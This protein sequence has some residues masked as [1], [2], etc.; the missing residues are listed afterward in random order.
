MLAGDAESGITSLSDADRAEKTP[1][2]RSTGHPVENQKQLKRSKE[3]K[4]ILNYLTQ[5]V[6]YL[7][8]VEILV[9]PVFILLVG[10]VAFAETGDITVNVEEGKFIFKDLHVETNASVML[11]GTVING[12]DK[13]WRYIQFEI[14][15]YDDKGELIKINKAK[16]PIVVLMSDFKSK[17][18][19]PLG[20][21]DRGA[22]IKRND[23][24]EVKAERFEIKFKDGAYPATYVLS[25][26]KPNVSKGLNYEDANINVAFDISKKEILFELKN[27]TDEPIKIDWN[28]VSYVDV[29]GASHRVI[30]QGVKYIDKENSLP[31]TII[32]PTAK[33]SDRLF[34]SNLVTYSSGAYGG[35]RES[36]LF[37]EAPEAKKFKNQK[38][39]VFMPLEVNGK[40]TNYFFSFKIDDVIN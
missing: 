19:K 1:H 39:S 17:E 11:K 13:N 9:I 12:T 33:I 10:S 26:L 28:Q 27:K 31:P 29:F 23:D 7:C 30:H 25:M 22:Y 14:S 4:K 37:P 24:I 21:G 15:M 20:S 2:G 40:V 34:P 16:K 18:E 8:P 6:N 38:F 35:W 32:P 5:V 3:M 36:N